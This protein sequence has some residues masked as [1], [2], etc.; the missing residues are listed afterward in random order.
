MFPEFSTPGDLCHFPSVSLVSIKEMIVLVATVTGEIQ[1]IRVP[2]TKQ[3][4][5]A[6]ACHTSYGEQ[7]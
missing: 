4:R 7:S 5:V 1:R 3:D 6:Y 2:I